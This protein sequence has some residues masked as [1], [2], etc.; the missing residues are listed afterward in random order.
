MPR[1][2]ILLSDPPIAAQFSPILGADQTPVSCVASKEEL[3]N[4]V[5]QVTPE[6]RLFAVATSVIVPAQVLE[7][8]Q[9]E[10][11]NFHPGP[12]ERPGLFPSVW[13]LYHGDKDFGVTIHRMTESVDAGEIID[14]QRFG[15]PEGAHRVDLDQLAFEAGSELI[16]R[17]ATR[18]RND[19]PIEPNGQE[20][21]SG[22]RTT[23]KDFAALCAL[24]SDVSQ[25]EF[26]RRYRAVGE[27]P[28]HALWIDLFG[29]RFALNNLRD[30]NTVVSGGQ[31]Q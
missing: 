23:A 6:S 11:Y 27:G 21:W 7:A 13:S 17:F 10:V 22:P 29:H 30:P 5:T 2:I 15:I 9:G 1:P 24:P 31:P 3:L 12:P 18:L 14:V 4:L 26:E 19:E 28:H 16:T 20:E 25:E 8:L